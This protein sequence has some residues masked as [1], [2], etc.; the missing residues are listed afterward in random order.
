MDLFGFRTVSLLLNNVKK[1]SERER[2]AMAMKTEKERKK[3]RCYSEM[4]KFSEE[5]S[6]VELEFGEFKQFHF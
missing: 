4:A 6:K 2:T 5:S 3:E 1:M